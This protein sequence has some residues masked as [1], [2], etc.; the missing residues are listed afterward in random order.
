[1]ASLLLEYATKIHNLLL[2]PPSK[3]PYDVHTH[4][5]V[6]EANS[7]LKATETTA[8]IEYQRAWRPETDT[9]TPTNATAAKWYCPWTSR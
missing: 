9:I 5:A 7:S 8:I 2:E 6:S 3:N 1:M 4:G